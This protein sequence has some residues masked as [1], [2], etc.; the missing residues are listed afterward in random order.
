MLKS[1]KFVVTPAS[2]VPGELWETGCGGDLCVK[3][4]VLP[5]GGC[6]GL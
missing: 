6:G 2:S 1:G 3:P 4:C 5:P